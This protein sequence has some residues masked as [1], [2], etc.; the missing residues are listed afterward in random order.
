MSSNKTY[1]NQIVHNIHTFLFV[2]TF[3][4]FITTILTATILSSIYVSADDS[5]V[6]EINITVPVSCTLSGTGMD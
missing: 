5:V 6:D 2:S 1:T 4:L 3:I